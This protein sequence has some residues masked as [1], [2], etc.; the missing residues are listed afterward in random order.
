MTTCLNLAGTRASWPKHVIFPMTYGC[1]VTHMP[2]LGSTWPIINV[3]SHKNVA[4]AKVRRSNLKRRA[5]VELI[6]L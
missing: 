1:K 2:A 6:I 3:S 5:S 4:N